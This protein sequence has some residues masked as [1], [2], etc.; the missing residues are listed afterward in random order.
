[1]RKTAIQSTCELTQT[2]GTVPDAQRQRK[3]R[4]DKENPILPSERYLKEHAIRRQNKTNPLGNAWSPILLL[5]QMNLRRKWRRSCLTSLEKSLKNLGA[6]HK[7]GDGLASKL[8]LAAVSIEYGEKPIGLK[9]K[10]W[11]PK[12]QM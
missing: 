5:K 7:N 8:P 12:D 4:M 10:V 1:M 2:S 3:D 6:T 11:W 9:I